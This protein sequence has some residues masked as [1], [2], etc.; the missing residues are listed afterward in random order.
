MPATGAGMTA[1]YCHSGAMRS[2]EPGIQGDTARLSFAA[3]DSGSHP[4]SA[5]ADFGIFKPISDKSE[6]GRAPE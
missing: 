5:I 6:I 2:I 4:K 3:L 1:L